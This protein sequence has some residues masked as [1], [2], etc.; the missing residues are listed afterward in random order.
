M[1]N[2]LLD[3]GG[4][5]P[6]T[7]NVPRAAKGTAASSSSAGGGNEASI[8]ESGENRVISAPRISPPLFSILY[9]S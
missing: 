2:V 4:P 9:N 6:P 1:I 7:P 8:T 5:P 3:E